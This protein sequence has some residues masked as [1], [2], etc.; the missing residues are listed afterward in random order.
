MKTKSID[1]SITEIANDT[2]L[3]KAEISMALNAKRLLNRDKLRKIVE[4]NYPL[5]PFIFGKSYLRNDTKQETPKS[6]PKESEK[7]SV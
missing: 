2:G 5:E 3:N 4:A 1:V 7:V 6:N